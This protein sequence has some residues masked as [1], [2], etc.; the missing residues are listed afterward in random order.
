ML[1]F[2]GTGREDIAVRHRHNLYRLWNAGPVVS[3]AGL[4]PA[5]VSLEG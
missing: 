2:A 1:M 3:E 4:E 5:T